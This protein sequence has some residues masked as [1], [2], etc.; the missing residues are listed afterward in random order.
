[1]WAMVGAGGLPGA[2]G[3]V[4]GGMLLHLWRT[5]H[6]LGPICRRGA[7]LAVVGASACGSRGLGRRYR[8]VW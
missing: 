4:R 2:P 6:T 3:C 7:G 8:A 1:M 5:L